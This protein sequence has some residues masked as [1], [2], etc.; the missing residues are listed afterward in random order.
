VTFKGNQEGIYIYIKEGNFQ[1]IK[2]QLEHKLKKAGT[3]FRG[4]KVINIKGKKL[5]T[6]ETEEIKGIIK[7]KY[8]LFIDEVKEDKQSRLSDDISS[9]NNTFFDGI[10]E[11]QTKFINTT[12]RSGQAIEYDGNVVIIGDINPGGIVTA[13]GNIIVLGALRGVAHAG[14]D[15]NRQAIVAAFLLQ[16]TQL[17]IADVI[18][19]RPD[20]E[21]QA[22]RWPEIAKIEENAV[23]IEPYLPK[24]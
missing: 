17:R 16:P 12:I 7:N 19:R 1:I 4:A 5:S 6:E 2:E 20:Y 11:G 9:I 21:I 23:L 18:A 13:K 3:F 22:S 14:S 15:G 10:Q 24:K 8:G